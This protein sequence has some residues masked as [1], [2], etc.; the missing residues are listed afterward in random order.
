MIS[1]SRNWCSRLQR[2]REAALLKSLKPLQIMVTQQTKTSWPQTQTWLTLIKPLRMMI[3]IFKSLN[4]SIIK[5]TT[6]RSGKNSVRAIS[7]A[8][9]LGWL[10]QKLFK[11]RS[12]AMT[13]MMTLTINLMMM[14]SWRGWRSNKRRRKMEMRATELIWTSLQEG[15]EWR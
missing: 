6:P 9:I 10:V 13:R 1:P 4:R 3:M 5:N 8:V 12:I 14:S 15:R 11:L 2:R 7:T